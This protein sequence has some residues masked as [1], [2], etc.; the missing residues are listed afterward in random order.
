[1]VQLYLKEVLEALTESIG[2]ASW[3]LKKQVSPL[4][5]PNTRG[6][7]HSNALTLTRHV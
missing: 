1:V 4:L 7:E 6:H 2:A 5:T 3:A